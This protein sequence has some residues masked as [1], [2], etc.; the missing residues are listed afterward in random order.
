MRYLLTLNGFRDARSWGCFAA[1]GA[2]LRASRSECA[3]QC[4]ALSLDFCQLLGPLWVFTGGGSE[5]APELLTVDA[6]LAQDA[7]K[8]AA[9]ELAMQRYHQRHGPIR[10]LQTN[11]AAAL[12][13]YRPAEPSERGYE[14]GAGNDGQPLAHAGSGNLRRTIPISSGRPSSRRPS[15]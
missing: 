1:L 4:A 6:S 13:D 5:E 10:V 15:T 3:A 12:T 14:L 7:D 9:L 2:E 11:V 8:R